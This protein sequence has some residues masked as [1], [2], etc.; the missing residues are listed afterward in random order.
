MGLYFV[1]VFFKAV[2]QVR[3]EMEGKIKYETFEIKLST[4]EKFL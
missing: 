3:L 1:T 4:M 2:S